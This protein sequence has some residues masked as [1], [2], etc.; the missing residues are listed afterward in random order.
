M[1]ALPYS[2]KLDRM[3]R[4]QAMPVLERRK[5]ML[6]AQGIAAALRDPVEEQQAIE[7]HLDAL[8]QLARWQAEEIEDQQRRMDMLA[9]WVSVLGVAL[10]GGILAALGW[11][12]AAAI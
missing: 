8:D 12:A 5:P 4:L 1:E 11:A 10:V 2:D 6:L 9:M 3:R 7:R